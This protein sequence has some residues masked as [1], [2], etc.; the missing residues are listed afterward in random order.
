MVHLIDFNN[1]TST[2]LYSWFWLIDCLSV[3]FVYCLLA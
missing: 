3:D 2:F 1:N